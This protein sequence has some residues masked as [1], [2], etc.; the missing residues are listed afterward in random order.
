MTDQE[1]LDLSNYMFK[2]PLID[3]IEV[4]MQNCAARS[5]RAGLQ[6][7]NFFYTF[8]NKVHERVSLLHWNLKKDNLSD[9]KAPHFAP[10]TTK[11]VKFGAR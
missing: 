11:T 8:Y 4:A 6:G 10:V 5:S 2:Y 9:E 3:V 1:Q 7:H